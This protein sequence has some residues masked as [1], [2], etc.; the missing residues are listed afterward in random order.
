MKRTPSPSMVAA[1]EER[2]GRVAEALES[3]PQPEALRQLA[4]FNRLLVQA[5]RVVECST[6]SE[7]LRIIRAYDQV[8]KDAKALLLETPAVEGGPPI[9]KVLRGDVP[10]S[11]AVKIARALRSA[12][13][14][15]RQRAAATQAAAAK[16]KG[17]PKAPIGR[18]VFAA[19]EEEAE[20]LKDR[21]AE[22]VALDAWNW[23]VSDGLSI[24][25]REPRS[26]VEITH[27]PDC[28]AD[29]TKR[30]CITSKDVVVRFTAGGEDYEVA[31]L[32]I[33]RHMHKAMKH[34][35]ITSGGST[36]D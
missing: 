27:W 25:F 16:S 30:E 5:A 2:A 33:W 9:G 14:T 17:L 24:D 13:A 3:A 1:V 21:P 23:L 28:C 35:G 31:A 18:A 26:G 22:T 34:F 6:I 32:T 19:I 29:L 8:M 12:G 15:K 36:D 4:E 11:A 20:R 7:H 10:M